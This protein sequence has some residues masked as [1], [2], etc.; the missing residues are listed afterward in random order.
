[1]QEEQQR[2]LGLQP[3][4]Q[5]NM[6]MDQKPCFDVICHMNGLTINEMEEFFIKIYDKMNC[7]PYDED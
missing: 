2:H 7:Q 1:M 3:E 6:H 5:F 4:V